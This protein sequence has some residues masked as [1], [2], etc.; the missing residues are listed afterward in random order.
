MQKVSEFID[1]KFEAFY[2]FRVVKA[3]LWWLVKL[4]GIFELKFFRTY[5]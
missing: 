3:P 4:N 5:S 2:E 1:L